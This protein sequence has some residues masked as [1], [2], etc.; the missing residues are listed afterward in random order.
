MRRS[1][2]LFGPIFLVAFGLV[3]LAIGLFTAIVGTR[4]ASAEAAR[5]EGLRPLTAAALDDGAPGREVLVEGRI[6]ERN[7]AL[8]RQFVAYAREEY[9]GGDDDKDTWQEDQRSTPPLLIEVADGAVS[10][11]KA[12]YV[13]DSP[14]HTWQESQSLSWNGL[15]GEGTKRYRGFQAGDVVMAIGTLAAGS[16]GMELRAERVYGGTRSAYIASRRSAARWIPWL[17][18]VF[19]VVGAGIAGGGVWW[20]ARR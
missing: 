13:L 7:P 9:R 2:S 11:A 12:G 19:A 1:G 8:F 18:G 5:A 14:P 17:G 4:E 10:L 6:S 20:L 3:F 16:E 15:T